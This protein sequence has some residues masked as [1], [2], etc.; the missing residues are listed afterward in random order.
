VNRIN[1]PLWMAISQHY[2]MTAGPDVLNSTAG[3]METALGSSRHASGAKRVFES[4]DS[5]SREKNSD[6]VMKPLG[7]EIT[8]CSR[9]QSNAHARQIRC[10]TRVL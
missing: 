1:A 8:A 4:Y 9:D 6:N 2:L 3:P 7:V 5:W 10:S